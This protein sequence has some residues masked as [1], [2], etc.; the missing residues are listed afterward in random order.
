MSRAENSS[1]ENETVEQKLVL[2]AE[3]LKQTKGKKVYGYL[4]RNTKDLIDSIVD[5][6]A[7]DKTI[8]ELY[9]L[10]YEK[11]HEILGTYFSK[12]PSKIPLSENQEFKSI[13]NAIIKEAMNLNQES[14]QKQTAAHQK[15]R[16]SAVA[17]TRLFRNLCGI[18]QGKLDDENRQTIHQSAVDRRIRREDEAKRNAELTYD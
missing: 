10:W 18:F 9:D 4:N 5:E 1:Y 14:N 7:K 12:R 13:K 11:K 15:S 17:V 2:L 6:L 16:V 3:K 8:A